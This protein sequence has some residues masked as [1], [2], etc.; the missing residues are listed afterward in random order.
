MLKFDSSFDG[1]SLPTTKLVTLHYFDFHG[2]DEVTI[3]VVEFLSDYWK[4]NACDW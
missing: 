4:Y 1:F 3:L 2:Y